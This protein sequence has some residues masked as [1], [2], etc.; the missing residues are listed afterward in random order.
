M[1]ASNTTVTGFTDARW[2]CLAY[3]FCSPCSK[4]DSKQ[5]TI[6]LQELLEEVDRDLDEFRK[7]H[8]S[9]YSVK[10]ITLWW[11]TEKERVLMRHEP[12]SV[13]KTIH[14]LRRVKWFAAFFVAGQLV[15]LA[16]QA[17]LG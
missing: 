7:K 17:M 14:E 1:M 8:A 3:R 2:R 16:A 9:D 6:G 10:N 13:V 5:L 4:M 11:G 12:D 15:L